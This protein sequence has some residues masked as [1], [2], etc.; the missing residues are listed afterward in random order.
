MWIIDCFF[1]GPKLLLYIFISGKGMVGF[2]YFS[3]IY[4]DKGLENEAS[5]LKSRLAGGIINVQ[6]NWI[7]II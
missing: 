1:I 4:V 7:I 5:Y 6:G 3:A 2:K